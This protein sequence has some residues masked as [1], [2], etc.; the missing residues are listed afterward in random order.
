MLVFGLTSSTFDFITFAAVRFLF[1]GDEVLF[2]TLWFIES[3]FTGLLIILLVRT[4]R[5]VFSSIPG[6][7]LIVAA[8]VV[9]AVTVALPFTPLAGMLGF[10]Q[11]TASM[12]ATIFGIA[13]L[14]GVGMETAK[15]IFY[16]TNR[17]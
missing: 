17:S 13:C 7:W 16:R 9:S 2:H 12:I 10:V 4:Q 14:Y 8:L 5:P 6:I 1:H 3:V 11:P 15:A